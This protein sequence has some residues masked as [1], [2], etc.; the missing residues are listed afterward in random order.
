[1]KKLAV[2]A[3]VCAALTATAA[4]VDGVAATVGSVLIMRSDVLAEMER[5]G[6]R[7]ESKYAEV[8]NRLVERE[9]ILKAAAASK[10]TMQDWVVEDRIRMIVEDSFGGNRSLFEAMLIERKI[11]ETEWRKRIK[12]DL[13]VNAMRWSMVD[14]NII[15]SP[16]KMK[17]EY[18]KNAARYSSGQKV[19]VSV[20]LLSPDK[21]AQKDEIT[22]LLRTTDF[23]EIAK[24]YS[25]D[26]KAKEGGVWKD[27]VPSDEFSQVVCDEISKTPVGAISNWIDMDGWSFLLRKDGETLA[28]VRPFSDAYAEIERNVKAAEAERLYKAWISRLKAD[29]YIKIH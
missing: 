23:S 20:I 27:I 11:S 7:D 17:E 19:S 14:K 6:I 29:T 24:K 12:E 5:S 16:D 2:I 13:V 10:M 9:L 15:A 21:V 4:E 22:K 26:V 3:A 18:R 1:M 28:A 25:S 8:R